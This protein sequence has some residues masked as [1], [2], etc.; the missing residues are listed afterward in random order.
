VVTGVMLVG[1]TISS[2]VEDSAL[3]ADTEP[4]TTTTEPR[5]TTTTVDPDVTVPATTKATIAAT[6]TTSSTLPPAVLEAL[7]QQMLTFLNWAPLGAGAYAEI[8]L[9]TAAVRTAGTANDQ[10]ALLKAC[11]SLQQKASET[12]PATWRGVLA[13]VN[14]GELTTSN[15][16]YADQL[17]KAGEVCPDQTWA[18]TSTFL[19]AADG[20]RF[21]IDARLEDIKDSADLLGFGDQWP[22]GL[23]PL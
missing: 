13:S 12:G 5:R 22:A 11:T 14:D 7:R 19:A 8:D 17:Q 3:V 2:I 18:V 4:T 10:P 15:V 20:T 21:K 6:T 1:F 9:A 16:S 23:A